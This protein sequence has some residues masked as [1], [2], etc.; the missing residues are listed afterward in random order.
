MDNFSNNR[1]LKTGVFRQND[2]KNRANAGESTTA[3][4]K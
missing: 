2:N 3:V 4:P 1:Y